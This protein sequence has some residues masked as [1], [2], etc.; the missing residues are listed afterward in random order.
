MKNLK[1]VRFLFIFSSLFILI[2]CQFDK[3]G[4]HK[5]G[6]Y[7]Q[8]SAFITASLWMLISTSEK[9]ILTSHEH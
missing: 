8:M 9:G 7:F 1:Y 4:F 3:T 5:W 2:Y 6:L